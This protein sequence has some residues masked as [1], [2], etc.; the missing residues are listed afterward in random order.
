LNPK[1][2][3]PSERE[4]E[5]R[6]DSVLKVIYLLYNEGYKPTQGSQV[7]NKDICDEAI[8]LGKLLEASE[9]SKNPMI[10]ALIALMLFQTA[11]FSTRM[12]ENGELIPM[13]DQDRS[14]W[15]QGLIL[16]G[17][18]HLNKSADSKHPSDYHILAGIAYNH[19]IAPDYESTD[20]KQ[21]LKLY[22]IQ[23]A[24]N[25]TP[26][27]NLNRVVAVAKVYGAQRGLEDLAKLH[28]TFKDYYLMHA[29]RGELLFESGRNEDAIDALLEAIKTVKNNS[30]KKFIE[31]KLSELNKKEKTAS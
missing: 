15:D 18:Y 10:H 20:W 11:R 30:E 16:N 3:L 31:K 8:H 21:I 4:M 13:K 26:I 9:L 12:G 2:E 7:I 5:K 17:V 1:L 28:E 19:C 23:I 14:K 24:I 25:P 6:L 27:S 22:D 29:I